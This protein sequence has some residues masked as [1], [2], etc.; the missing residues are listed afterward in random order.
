MTDAVEYVLFGK[1]GRSHI[2][3]PD[4]N[5]QPAAYCGLWIWPNDTRISEPLHRVCRN[6]ER[7]HK[8]AA[9]R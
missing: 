4:A 2:V 3:N 8:K 6:C 7:S 9:D 5:E 1:T